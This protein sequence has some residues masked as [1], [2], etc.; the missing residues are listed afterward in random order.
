MGVAGRRLDGIGRGGSFRGGGIRAVRSV[1][2]GGS[3]WH[4]SRPTRHEP[5]LRGMVSC[6]VP[7]LPRYGFEGLGL[8]PSPRFGLFSPCTSKSFSVKDRR[9]LD[10]PIDEHRRT[11]VDDVSLGRRD[12]GEAGLGAS[13]ARTARFAKLNSTRV[14]QSLVVVSRTRRQHLS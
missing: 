1:D 6:T 2:R 4:R 9:D 5:P 7:G 13:R 11:K 14:S 8:P 12:E 3:S 10:Q